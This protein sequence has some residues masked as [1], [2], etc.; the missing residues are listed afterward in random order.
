MMAFF[1]W[2]KAAVRDW[3]DPPFIT[4]DGV[5]ALP[6][7]PKSRAIYIVIEDGF[8]ENA[9]MRCPCGCGSV[10]H[11]NLIPDE[12]PCWRVIRHQNGTTSLFPSV[13]RKKGCQSHFWF[14]EGRVIWCPPDELPSD[15][16]RL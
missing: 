1:N 14:R 4:V 11:M 7:N 8:E 15:D 2:L 5:R 6:T 16:A 13:W 10:L 3:F 9:S 12:R